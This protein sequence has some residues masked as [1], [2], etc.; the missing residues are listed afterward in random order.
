MFADRALTAVGQMRPGDHLFLGYDTD[1]ERES[2][3]ASFVLDGLAGGH[4]T[5]V[6]PP[7][8]APADVALGFL[9]RHGLDPRPALAAR[10]IVVDP[11]LSRGYEGLWEVDALVA[12]EAARAVRDGLLGLRVSMEVPRCSA[13]PSLDMLRESE[14]LLDK[15]FSTHPVLGICSYDRRS[16]SPGE[17]APLDALHHGRVGSDDIGQDGLLRITRTFAPPGL[18]LVG[19]VDDSH[20]TALARALRTEAERSEQ[21]TGRD[22]DIRLDLRELGFIDV[23][24][25]RLLVFLALGMHHSG[26]RRLILHGLAPQLRKVMRVTGWDLVPGLIFDQ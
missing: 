21:R 15:V 14:L 3:V 17:L 19:D 24:A 1:E 7:T 13:D 22:Q 8:D 6:L 26:G 9:E 2:I 5:L 25:L 20:V 16:F 12:G 11:A 4:R 10:Q 23:G 18:A